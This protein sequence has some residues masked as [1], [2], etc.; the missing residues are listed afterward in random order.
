MSIL[1]RGGLDDVFVSMKREKRRK[2]KESVRPVWAGGYVSSPAA[3]E[4]QLLVVVLSGCTNLCVCPMSCYF[5][6]PSTPTYPLAHN[7]K[8]H[9]SHWS[10]GH[11]VGRPRRRG[12][13]SRFA[14]P[15][16]CCWQLPTKPTNQTSPCPSICASL[17]QAPK[18]SK[19]SKISTSPKIRTTLP[20]SSPV[21][22]RPRP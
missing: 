12:N 14:P 8:L 13:G 2:R 5:S 22:T 16:A 9:W 20:H 11:A 7:R 4:A 6:S 17:R 10:R 19:M 18:M 1:D 3:R 15:T 21:P